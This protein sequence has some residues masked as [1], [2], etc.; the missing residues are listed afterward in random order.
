M[1]TE[2][3][4]PEDVSVKRREKEDRTPTECSPSELIKSGYGLNKPTECLINKQVMDII[5][6]ELTNKASSSTRTPKQESL[7]ESHSP[8]KVETPE[9]STSEHYQDDK[10]Q[11]QAAME[12]QENERQHQDG[13]QIE[14]A[15]TGSE[16]NEVNKEITKGAEQGEE[17]EHDIRDCSPLTFTE[18]PNLKIDGKETSKDRRTLD[19]QLEVFSDQ[20]ESTKEIPET[21]DKETKISHEDENRGA[22]RDQSTDMESTEQ[23]TST[24]EATLGQKRE[25][26]NTDMETKSLSNDDEREIKACVEDENKDNKFSSDTLYFGD[27]CRETSSKREQNEK[28]ESFSELKGEEKGP[29]PED[30][31][32]IKNIENDKDEEYDPVNGRTGNASIV[33]VTLQ[34]DSHIGDNSTELEKPPLAL[35]TDGDSTQEAEIEADRTFEE[36]SGIACKEKNQDLHESRR[37]EKNVHPVDK[38]DKAQES[39]GGNIDEEAASEVDISIKDPTEASEDSKMVTTENEDLERSSCQ[40]IEQVENKL[41]IQA[42]MMSESTEV[43]APRENPETE[44]CQKE[45]QYIK[46]P[47][48]SHEEIG[49]EDEPISTSDINHKAHNTIHTLQILPLLDSNEKT[50]SAKEEFQDNDATTLNIK[51]PMVETEKAVGGTANEASKSEHLEK[52]EGSN[53]GCVEKEK[54][55][56]Y[57]SEP[58]KA[59]RSK[60]TE[61]TT[62]ERTEIVELISKTSNSMEELK[63]VHDLGS[64]EKLK[65]NYG[66]EN[67]P[68]KTKKKKEDTI[69][70]ESAA[71]V[72]G[73]STIR[74]IEKS[75]Q[76]ESYKEAQSNLSND[77]KSHRSENE[78]RDEPSIRSR[79]GISKEQEIGRIKRRNNKGLSKQ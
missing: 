39:V 41:E 46:D 57:T 31:R 33:S 45:Q 78:A 32:S 38:M 48:E 76:E 77:D 65:V 72:S 28:E 55:V 64:D 34:A 30:I 52:V 20:Q 29:D 69:E 25:V 53:T 79:E 37:D 11:N 56:N 18:E 7:V 74:F 10:I 63:E 5:G 66:G 13:A 26:P 8:D 40:Q 3:D 24:V 51:Y 59:M 50:E 44:T 47:V 17:I 1:A 68:E 62:M 6:V 60:I 67:M 15:A 71:N 61:D 75:F 14:D 19:Q 42:N 27:E 4:I 73:S 54:Q 70:D 2:A 43:A 23:V 35:E 21:M 58:C 36:A 12:I 22:E 9:S 16:K 49:M